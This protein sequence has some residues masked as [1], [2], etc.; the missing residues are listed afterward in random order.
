MLGLFLGAT[1]HQLGFAIGNAED[2][3]GVRLRGAHHLDTFVA[4]FLLHD[5]KIFVGI[6]QNAFG[7]GFGVAQGLFV[8]FLCLQQQ[9]SRIFLCCFRKLFGTAS[10]FLGLFYQ[11]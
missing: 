3:L 6:V 2:T 10:V 11:F 1:D 9:G 7:L 8:L 4:R 5:F